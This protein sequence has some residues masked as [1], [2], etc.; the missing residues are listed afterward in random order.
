MEMT[1]KARW[2]SISAGVLAASTSAAVAESYCVACYGP[3][4][5]YRCVI[6]D[7]PPSAA[8]DPR[9]QVQCIKQ[10]AKSGGHSRCSVERFSTAN[11]NGAEKLVST[12]DALPVA[13]PPPVTG[14]QSPSAA[15]K[16]ADGGTAKEPGTEPAPAQTP[17]TMEELAKSAA[18]STTE[19]LND[20]GGTVKSTTEKAGET[21]GGMGAA[22]GNAAKKS[23]NCLTSLFNDC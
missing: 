16:P 4:A 10:L 18:A 13:G 15:P 21:I 22:V 7:V 20:V 8:P 2:V 5:V 1:R 6:A 19:S 17:Q 9:N 3:D 14:E 23:W 11:C 12:A